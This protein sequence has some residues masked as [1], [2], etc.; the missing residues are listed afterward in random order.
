MKA[1][2]YSKLREKLKEIEPQ[3]DIRLVKKKINVLRS[4]YRRELKKIRDT[5]ASRTSEEYEYE[6]TLWYF[7]DID[8]LRHQETEDPGNS[9]MDDLHQTESGSSVVSKKHQ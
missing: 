9:M 7:S 4:G 2:A 1:A 6:P 8:F 3:A 5:F